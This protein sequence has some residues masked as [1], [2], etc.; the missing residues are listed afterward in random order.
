LSPGA[1]TERQGKVLTDDGAGR[2][3]EA[4]MSFRELTMIDV[5]E[6]LRRLQAGQ[7]ARQLAR[8][9]V[10]DRKTAGRY[11]AAARACDVRPET[12]VTDAL[13]ADVARRVQSRPDVPPSE[14]QAV[15]ETHRAQMERWLRGDRPLRLVRVH[16]LL[17]REGVEVGYTTLRRFVHAQLGWRERPSTVRVDDP[18]LGEEAQIDFGHVGWVT[19]DDGVR[20]K[21]WALVV[22]LT[23]SRYMFVWPLLAQTTLALCEGLDAAWRFFGGIPKRIVPDNMTSAVVRPDAKD[24]G[25]Q[26]GFMEYAQARGFFV[27]PARVRRPQDKPRVE[28]Q[29][30]YVRE[31]CF[32]GETIVSVPQA[33]EHAETWCRDVAGA[34]VHGTTRRVPREVYETEEKEHM[35]PAPTAA[36]D[37]PTWTRAKVHPD[38]H[39]QVARSLYSVPTAYLGQRLEVRIDRVSVRLYRGSDLVKMHMRV[40]PGKRATDPRDYP[41][42]KADYATRS[43]ERICAQARARGGHVGDFVAKLLDGPLPW[44]KMRQAYGLLRQCDRYGNAKVDALC[45]RSL[46]FGVLDV[47]RIER[48]LKAA[49][50]IESEGEREGRV[51]T[52]PVARFARDPATFATRQPG[53]ED[54]G[55]P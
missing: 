55:A 8:D 30:A 37:V 27:D 41:E 18:P 46:A 43:V 49:T 26:R 25:I 15:L 13:V 32:D 52:L 2:R 45:N 14:V 28:N 24:P 29:I 33:R 5:R 21:L 38:H 19:T 50:K 9:G 10:V 7:S 35:L 39:V 12:V 48:M 11:L 6:V 42:G 1:T 4:P 53:R 44:T 40:A 34:R 17:A 51:V 23:V 36:F 31:R 20:R 3:R 16:E 47:G 22:T 54:G